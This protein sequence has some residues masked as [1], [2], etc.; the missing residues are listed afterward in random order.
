M[1][2][3]KKRPLK[4]FVQHYCSDERR[5]RRKVIKAI[6]IRQFKRQQRE[7]MGVSV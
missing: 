2:T 4:G 3:A 7:F 1:A 5:A 6:G